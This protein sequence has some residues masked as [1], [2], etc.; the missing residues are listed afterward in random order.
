MFFSGFNFFLALSILSSDREG[1]VTTVQAALFIYLHGSN[2]PSPHR[3]LPLFVKIAA[4]SVF[5]GSLSHLLA[6]LNNKCLH[7]VFLYNGL[8]S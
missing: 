1:A 5:L 8:K 7:T 3:K 4:P 6:S 2:S